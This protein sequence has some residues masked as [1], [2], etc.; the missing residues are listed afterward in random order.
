M[1][2]LILLA[3]TGLFGWWGIWVSGRGETK[4]RDEEQ[5]RSEG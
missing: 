2:V 4:R 3:F 1:E 5:R